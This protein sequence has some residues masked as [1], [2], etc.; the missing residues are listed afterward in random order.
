MFNALGYD[1]WSWNNDYNDVPTYFNWAENEPSINPDTD[2]NYVQ[3]MQGYDNGM[4]YPTGKWFVPQDQTEPGYY[5][6]QS[7]KVPTNPTTINPETSTANQDLKCMPGY[8]DVVQNSG[9]CYYFSSS[10]NIRTRQEAVAVC[11]KL[12]DF[13]YDGVDYN[14]ENTQLVSISSDYENDAL[15]N[16][17]YYSLNIQSAWIGLSWNGKENYDLSNSSKV[18]SVKF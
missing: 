1:D 15:F 14:P 3:L 2:I 10:E 6:C 4:D 5:V 8:Q 13:G 9:K 16:E 11:D 18:S 17:M 12:M 7:P